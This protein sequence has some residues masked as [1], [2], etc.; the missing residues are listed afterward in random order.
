M[1]NNF[2][3]ILLEKFLKG[4]KIVP[5]QSIHLGFEDCNDDSM[6]KEG[7]NESKEEEGCNLLW[8]LPMENIQYEEL[9]DHG[10]N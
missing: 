6:S 4:A 2:N 1:S 8:V 10:M 3:N 9:S 5:L 7:V